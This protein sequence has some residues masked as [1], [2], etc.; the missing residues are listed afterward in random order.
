MLKKIFI[1]SGLLFLGIFTVL[2]PRPISSAPANISADIPEIRL[3]ISPA[4]NKITL[5]PG[6]EQDYALTVTNT[7]SETVAFKV[8]ASPY[9]TI[10]D[11]YYDLDFDTETRYT[12]IS[13]WITFEQ[14]E[15]SLDAG[16][17]T[18][19]NYHIS[20]PL[21]VPGG[22]QYATVFVESDVDSDQ[23]V[24]GMPTVARLGEVIYARVSGK[25]REGADITDYS[26]TGFL[27][28]G[29]IS[30]ASKVTNTGNTDFEA[31]HHLNIQTIF[32]TQVYQ[33]DERHIVFPDT[34]RKTSIVWEGTHPIGIFKV[35]YK[36]TALDKEQDETRIVFVI[37][38]F[39]IIIIL[40]LLT[41]AVI[42]IIMLARRHRR[43]KAMKLS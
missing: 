23:I 39:L 29:D 34:S 20:V 9:S 41:L 2:L 27:L 33:Q 5:D 32:G 31:H 11:D 18:K 37:P 30:V 6:D 17:D 40:I 4:E 28:S 25:T 10:G 12:Q 36:V 43:R 16:E 13:R 15:Y 3:K 42:W 19:V 22:G 21:D 38:I 35:N 24:E 8:Y 1:A 14:E 26:V 7:G